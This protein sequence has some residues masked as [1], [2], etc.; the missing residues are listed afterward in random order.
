[1]FLTGGAGFIGSHTAE[2][3]LRR[4]DDVI[5]VDEVNNYYDTSI[6]QEN[7]D[8]LKKIVDDGEQG[9]GGKPVGSFKFFKSDICEKDFI[10]K[11]FKDEEDSGMYLCL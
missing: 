3:L 2:F 7:L 9:N 4:G 10:Q 11:I 8:L 1:M 6:K 5:V